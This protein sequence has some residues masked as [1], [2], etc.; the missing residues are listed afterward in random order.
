VYDTSRNT[1]NVRRSTTTTG[2]NSGR[3]TGKKD[4]GNHV[5]R[6]VNNNDNYMSPLLIFTFNRHQYLAETLDYV[7]KSIGRSCRFGCPIVVSED[8]HHPEIGQ[9]ILDY[10]SKFD[11][12]GIPLVHI[13]HEQEKIPTTPNM[14]L[15]RWSYQALAKHYGWALSKVFNGKVHSDY[16]SP[17]RVIILEEDIRVAVDFFSY[18]EA[19]SKLLDDDPTLFAV[20]AFNDNGHQGKDPKR[21]LRSDFFPGLGWMMTKSLWKTELEAKWPIGCKFLRLI[22][23][24]CLSTLSCWHIF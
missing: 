5:G 19:T 24:R 12:L 7:H 22:I 9:V 4:I 10:K 15:T 3:A 16:P 13:H 6:V 8:G 1:N 18:M 2:Y 11:A 17:Q 21:L 20:S 14:D 23:V